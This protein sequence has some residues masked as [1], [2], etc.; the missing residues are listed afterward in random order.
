[1]ARRFLLGKIPLPPC[2]FCRLSTQ[3]SANI[4]T[5]TASTPKT[6]PSAMPSVRSLG[7]PFDS[8]ASADGS[9]SLAVLVSVASG[10]FTSWLD[11][12]AVANVVGDVVGDVADGVLVYVDPSMTTTL[13][14]VSVATSDIVVDG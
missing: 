1:V 10:R 4:I 11:N 5:A 7:G 8:F 12:G 14:Q 9:G 2:F 6:T 13:G 3:H